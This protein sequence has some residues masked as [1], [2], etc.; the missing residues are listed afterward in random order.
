M[1]TKGFIIPTWDSN[2]KELVF[3]RKPFN[4]PES[5]EQWKKIGHNYENYTGEMID[6]QNENLPK[7]C[8]DI[9]KNF[10]L[11]NIGVVLYKMSPGCILPKHIDTFKKFKE[12][13]NLN[14]KIKEIWRAVIFL[15]DWQSGHYFEIS[16]NPITN[17][18]AGDY[19]MWKG[20]EPHIAANIGSTDR[21]TLQIT[22]SKN[23]S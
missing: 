3:V 19:I 9:A 10:K 11:D 15:E 8:I 23:V 20:S 1:W 2:Y 21:Y 12:V 5:L 22:G 18:S 4:D 7:W 13:H 6:I 16:D 17:W 14:T